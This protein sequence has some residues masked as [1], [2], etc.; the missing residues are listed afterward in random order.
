MSASGE[1]VSLVL[2]LRFG[3]L[4]FISNN[5]LCFTGAAVPHGGKIISFGQHRIYI[6]ITPVE[7]PREVLTFPDEPFIGASWMAYNMPVKNVQAAAV[8]AT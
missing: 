4:D 7:Y 5:A 2:V 8:V 3:L 1:R 6:A